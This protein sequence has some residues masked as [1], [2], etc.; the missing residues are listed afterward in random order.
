[1]LSEKSYPHPQNAMEFAEYFNPTRQTN[2]PQPKVH[3]IQI[4]ERLAPNPSVFVVP[5]CSNAS[6]RLGLEVF[7]LGLCK[8]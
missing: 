7:S 5:T 8:L 4:C 1:M 2:A 6:N 3:R